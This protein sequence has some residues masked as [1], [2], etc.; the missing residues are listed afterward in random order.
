MRWK[1]RSALASCR[2]C[3]KCG[4]IISVVRVGVSIVSVAIVSVSIVSVAMVS[5]AIVSVSIARQ[6]PHLRGHSKCG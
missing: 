1:K 6:L 4:P 2:T 5:V 3:V